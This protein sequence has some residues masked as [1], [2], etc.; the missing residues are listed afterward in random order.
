MTVTDWIMV[1][2]VALALIG[3]VAGARCTTAS[4]GRSLTL[5]TSGTTPAVCKTPEA[6]PSPSIVRSPTGESETIAYAA[7]PLGIRL[8]AYCQAGDVP[9]SATAVQDPGGDGA[10][11]TTV[12]SGTNINTG[13]GWV[14][15]SAQNNDGYRF[16]VGHVEVTCGNRTPSP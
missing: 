12:G 14:D 2:V 3:A 11:I 5:T 13:K 6:D 4:T 9:L 15:V 7:G 16:A 10:T 8:E 1:V